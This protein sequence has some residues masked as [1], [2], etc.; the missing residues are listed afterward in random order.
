MT[1]KE[2]DAELEARGRQFLEP[3]ARSAA[4]LWGAHAILAMGG[5]PQRVAEIIQARLGSRPAGP[6]GR[7]ATGTFDVLAA[8]TLICRW[9]D[10]L[11]EPAHARVREALTRGILHRGNTENHWLMHY[12]GTLLATERWPDVEV[13]GNGLSR[14]ATRAEATRWILGMIDRTARL[15][16]YEYDSTQYHP[17]HLL[18]MIAL[19]DH[20]RD[21]RLRA[22]AGRMATLYVA[23]MAL[24]Y[25]HGAWAGGHSREGYRQNTWTLVGASASLGFYYF[26]DAPFDPEVHRDEMACPAMTARFRPPPLLADLARDRSKPRVV[27]KTKAPRAIYRHADR[28]ARPVRK[29]T[30]LSPSFALGSTQVNL[31]GAPAGPIDLVSWDLSWA[32]P[33]HQATLVCGHPCLSP[34]R[35]SAFL[36]GLP[37]AIGRAVAAPKP[38]LQNP[39]RLFGASPYER[40]MQH[41]S[42]LLVLYRIPPEDPAPYV[43]LYLPKAVAWTER[44]GWVLGD[45]GAFYVGLRPVGDCRWQEIWEEGHLD[46]YLIRV[47]GRD[48]GLALEAEEARSVGTFDNFCEEMVSPRLDLSGWPEPGRVRFETLGG[49]E[50]ELIYDGPHRVDGTEIDYASWPLYEAPGV[51]APPGAGRILFCLKGERLELDFEVDPSRPMLPMRVIG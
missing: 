38:Y 46:G 8:M 41:E 29:Y 40:M 49:H 47:E 34:G 14:E 50:L 28:E 21:P 23:D 22:L 6:F 51:E 15:G 48:V 44:E 19:T 31:P 2:Y 36:S 13:W 32:G 20:A 7:V 45:A 12:A 4:S 17:C 16:H 35:F 11:P 39:D 33:K 18:S 3:V 27:K 30:Y 24:E 1:R 43:N 37:Q 10:L 42:A 25:F 9:G 26:G 5:D